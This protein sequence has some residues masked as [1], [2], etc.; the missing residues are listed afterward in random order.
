MGRYYN[1]DI[2]G[3]FWFGVQSSD[4]ASFFGGQ[5]SEPNYIDYYF[6]KEGDM[7]EIKEGLEQCKKELGENF[8]KLEDFF[9]SHEMYN[10]AELSEKTGIPMDTVKHYLEWYARYTL[11]KKIHDCV[12]KHGSCSFTAEL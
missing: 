3:K 9:N 4:D 1:G 11:G 2:D 7:E 5:E 10:D 6:D 12:E 8:Q